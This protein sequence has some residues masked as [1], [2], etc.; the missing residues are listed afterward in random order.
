MFK[1][2]KPAIE[3][4]NAGQETK[5]KKLL[6]QAFGNDVY[7]PKYNQ[8]IGYPAYYGL[9]EFDYGV[10]IIPFKNMYDL[11]NDNVPCASAEGF[12]LMSL[13]QFEDVLSKGIKDEQKN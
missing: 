6:K 2:I 1:T 12:T 8:K 4:S 11:T 5:L 10:Y 3:V 7:F 13:Y 9:R